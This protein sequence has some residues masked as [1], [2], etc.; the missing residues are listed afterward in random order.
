MGV[1]NRTAVLSL[2]I[3]LNSQNKRFCP[4]NHVE[5]RHIVNRS[6]NN[7]IRNKTEKEKNI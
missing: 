5:D 4:I 3:N 6:I 1:L 2:C 7:E